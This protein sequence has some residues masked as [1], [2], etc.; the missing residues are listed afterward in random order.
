MLHVKLALILSYQREIMI[1]KHFIRYKDIKLMELIYNSL[2][3]KIKP[4]CRLNH[5]RAQR[6]IQF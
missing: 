3:Y 1:I 4:I 2:I 5:Y 6:N